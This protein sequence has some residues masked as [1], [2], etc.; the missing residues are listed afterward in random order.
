MWHELCFRVSRGRAPGIGASRG[1]QGE[2]HLVRKAGS[3]CLIALVGAAFLMAGCAARTGDTAEPAAEG[4]EALATSVAP[5]RLRSGDEL[6]LRFLTDSEYDYVTPVT[7]S[8]TV[9]VP[10]GQEVRASGRT[11]AELKAVVEAAM[12][13]Y[14]LDPA[15]T[16]TIQ[17]IA[18]KPV[19][20]IGEVKKPGRI[21]YEG[22]ITVSQALAAAGGLE[23]A[24]KPSSVMVVRTTGVAEPTAFRVDISKVL[25]GRDLSEDAPLQPNDVVYVPKSVIGQVGEFVQL[26]FENIAPAQLFY[27][28]GY[29][30]FENTNLRWIE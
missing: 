17:R 19:Y 1:R 3:V 23:A 7:P 4:R 20:V 6:S 21:E 14:L 18:V 16:V 15:V 28:R 9:V 2:S 8:G 12:T 13:D 24:G 29:E 5:Y 25:S 30:M 22:L 27:L 26:F 10:S 11:L